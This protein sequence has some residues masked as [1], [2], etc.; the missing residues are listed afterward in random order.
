MIEKNHL[1]C[2]VVAQVSAEQSE[3]VVI[4]VEKGGVLPYLAPGHS[5]H[6]LRLL[7][8][9]RPLGGGRLGGSLARRQ[10]LSLNDLRGFHQ[11]N[12]LFGLQLYLVRSDLKLYKLQ[13]LSCK[14]VKV[15]V[16]DITISMK[17]SY[18]NSRWN[19]D[20]ELHKIILRKSI[21]FLLNL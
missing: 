18:R 16:Y 10:L 21:H 3:V 19:A 15:V 20:C 4:P 9:P 13:K 14:V 17:K 5:D 11:L 1:I 6:L 7:R 12:H 2:D 8:L